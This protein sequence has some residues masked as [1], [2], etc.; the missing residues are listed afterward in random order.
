ML[1]IILK[2][3]PNSKASFKMINFYNQESF[4]QNQW[5]ESIIQWKIIMKCP[6]N[7]F[8]KRITSLQFHLNYEQLLQVWRPRKAHFM[9]RES[10]FESLAQLVLKDQNREWYIVWRWSSLNKRIKTATNAV[11]RIISENLM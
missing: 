11:N 2:H 7:S 9:S 5:C 4:N 8:K 1:F 6:N 3:H 10:A